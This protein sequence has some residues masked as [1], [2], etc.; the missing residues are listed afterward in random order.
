MGSPYLIRPFVPVAKT[1][2]LLYEK[3]QRD[4]CR[5]I[6]MN[7]IACWSFVCRKSFVLAGPIRPHTVWFPVFCVAVLSLVKIDQN[8]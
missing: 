6:K 2:F 3:F 8:S 4:G 5:K 1:S 7:V